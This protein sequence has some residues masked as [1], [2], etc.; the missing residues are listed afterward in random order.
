VLCGKATAA[1]WSNEQCVYD[2]LKFD[3]FHSRSGQW[4][5]T[6]SEKELTV[7]GQIFRE[8]VSGAMQAQWW[9]ASSGPP[10]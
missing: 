6:P 9:F 2:I 4:M 5:A 8:R 7:L 10:P 1:V 3:F